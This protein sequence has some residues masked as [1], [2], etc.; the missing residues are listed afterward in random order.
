MWNPWPSRR[1]GAALGIVLCGAAAV[2]GERPRLPPE[3]RAA[4]IRVL[5]VL[6]AEGGRLARQVKRLGAELAA[7]RGPLVCARGLDEAD[8]IVQFTGYRRTLDE[9]AG[10]L[11]WWEG[12][13]KLLRPGAREAQEAHGFPDRFSVVI[14]GR[15][16]WEVEAVLDGLARTLGRALDRAPGRETPPGRGDSI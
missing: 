7:A 10:S 5:L 12:Q 4:P 8:A 3:A 14:G 13:F 2:A 1:T 9:K 16:S 15:E 6:P 11:D